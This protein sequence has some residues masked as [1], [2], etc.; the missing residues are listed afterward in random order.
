MATLKNKR[1]ASLLVYAIIGIIIAVVMLTFMVPIIG[2]FL[3]EFPVIKGAVVS[4][5]DLVCFGGGKDNSIHC[6]NK[7]TGLEIFT[8]EKANSRNWKSGAFSTPVLRQEGLYF[9]IG[10]HVCAYGSGG[11]LWDNCM[12][13]S[14]IVTTDLEVDDNFVC[15][16]T[17]VNQYVCLERSYGALAFTIEAG[18]SDCPGDKCKTQEK[19]TLA[20]DFLYAALGNK[21]CKYDKFSLHGNV[22]DNLGLWGNC[23]QFINNIESGIEVKDGLVCFGA[24]KDNFVSCVKDKGAD[25][26]QVFKS[27]KTGLAQS[28]PHIEDSI[29]YFALDSELQRWQSLVDDADILT[30]ALAAEVPTDLAV[31]DDLICFGGADKINCR[32][33]D[34]LINRFFIGAPKSEDGT[35]KWD[36][37]EAISTPK[38]SN[39]YLYFGLG[40]HV[41]AYDAQALNDAAPLTPGNVV[42][43]PETDINEDNKEWYIRE[44]WCAD[45]NY[46]IPT[47]MAA[48]EQEGASE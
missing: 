36:F 14:G 42:Y 26:T 46:Q 30:R 5:Q 8:F 32:E 43:L 34:T 19:P 35:Y 31:S 9:A 21:I 10:N 3:D 13:I 28:K 23:P 48:L 12:Q 18:W 27:I 45:F 38:F 25:V 33:K 1:G 4:S 17:S 22:E 47:G 37:H 24:G 6:L 44:R 20:G 11:S 16:G 2:N 29:V 15:F 39:N 40:D 7:L 41:C